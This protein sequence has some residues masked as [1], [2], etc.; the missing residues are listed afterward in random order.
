MNTGPNLNH[1]DELIEALRSILMGEKGAT[2]TAKRLLARLPNRGKAV[3]PLR[4]V[5]E[6]AAPALAPLRGRDLF[7]MR[8]AI[9]SAVRQKIAKPT[10]RARLIELCEHTLLRAFLAVGDGHELALE[11][12]DAH[13]ENT[14]DAQA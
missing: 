1:Y 7:M 11:I 8:E 13:E 12:R 3:I 6:D 9:T 4:A 14:E 2:D 5:S 10:H